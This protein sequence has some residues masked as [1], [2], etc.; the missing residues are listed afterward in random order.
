[1]G[2]LTLGFREPSLAGEATHIGHG[3]CWKRT[4][5]RLGA[6]ETAQGE[7]ATRVRRSQEREAEDSERRARSR[8]EGTGEGLGAIP[9][10]R[11]R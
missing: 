5:A 9:T 3:P 4:V 8:A 1:M 2:F 7:E 11:T 6:A 10:M